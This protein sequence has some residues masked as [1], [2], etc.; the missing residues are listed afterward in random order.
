MAKNSSMATALGLGAAA[1]LASQAFVP[2][3][4]APVQPNAP[5]MRGA[6]AEQAQ[7]S[8]SSS[9]FAAGVASVSA[10]TAAV[11]ALRAFSGA[12]A[13]RRSIET[14]AFANGREINNSYSI[15]DPGSEE[16]KFIK[17]L[18][19]DLGF[20]GGLLGSESGFG[21]YNFDPLNLAEKNPEALPWYREAE[22]KHGRICMLA[23]LGLVVPEFI[24]IPGPAPCYTASVID[25]HKYC[26][27]STLENMDDQRGPLLHIFLFTFVIEMT[28]TYPKIMEGITK[29]NAGDYRLGVN[30]LPKEDEKIQEMKLKELKNGRLAMVA[31]GGAITQAVLSGNSFPWLYAAGNSSASGPGFGSSVPAA[32]GSAIGSSKITMH[33][34]GGG[35]KMSKAVPFLPVSPALEGYVGE[36]DGFDPLGFSLAID[37]RWLR[38]AELKHARVCMLAVTGWIT[39]DLGM[40]VPGEIFQVSTVEAHD[41]AVKTGAFPQLLCW[42]GYAEIFGFLAITNMMEGTTERKPGD[43]GLR[44]LYPSDEK[45]Q[46]DMQLKEL[47]NGRLAMLAFSGC[48]TASVLSGQT[49]PFFQALE[50]PTSSGVATRALETSRSLPFLPKPK[51]LKGFV[52]EEAEFDPLEFSKTFDIRWLRE[53][54]LKH[55]R[56]CMLAASGFLLQSSVADVPDALQ[57]VYAVPPVWAVAL[58]GFGGYVESTTYGGKITMLDM[59]DGPA[60]DR[61]PGDFNFGSGFMKGV[62]PGYGGSEKEQYDLKLRELNNGRLAMLA[63]SGMVHHNLVVKGPL[64]PLVPDGWAGPQGSWQV[65][66]FMGYIGGVEP[67]GLIH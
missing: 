35:Y 57:A 27:T 56:V 63:F 22:L 6:A 44:W 59:F 33:A 54:E 11:I 28:T 58:L 60:K 36:E 30:F 66:S 7:S 10:G 23:W 40:R 29:E 51:N 46:Y 25:A 34:A 26:V 14:K 19:K 65:Q 9:S 20:A 32:K 31:F 53:A 37:I 42:L 17:G 1:A 55:G 50:G 2:G 48:A 8:K 61:A 16:D 47:R 24:R 21:T 4:V 67:E 3:G 12:R 43:F 62:W 38:E 15:A 13:N 39:T 52:G 64:F 18:Q 49:W 5:S 45:S 41:A